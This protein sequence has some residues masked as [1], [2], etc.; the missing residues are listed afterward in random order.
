MNQ[1]QQI[2]FVNL[3]NWAYYP[4]EFCDHKLKKLGGIFAR[5]ANLIMNMMIRW[6]SKEEP[7]IFERKHP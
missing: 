3:N 2:V 1:I 4:Y 6:G 5:I 7:I